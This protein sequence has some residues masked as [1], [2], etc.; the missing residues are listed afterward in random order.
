MSDSSNAK[1][2]YNFYLKKKTA[3][4]VVIEHPKTSHKFSKTRR[5]P[6]K[7]SQGGSGKS[8]NN[9]LFGKTKK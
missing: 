3:T 4:S 6:E 5:R 9:Y 7:I 2:C 1:E 8:S